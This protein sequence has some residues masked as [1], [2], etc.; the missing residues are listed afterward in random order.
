MV[1]ARKPSS[2]EVLSFARALLRA[3]REAECYAEEHC[4]VN[5]DPGTESCLVTSATFHSSTNASTP[6]LPSA[7]SQKQLQDLYDY[8]IRNSV[9]DLCS[10]LLAILPRG[11]TRNGRIEAALSPN[12]RHPI[13]FGST[14]LVAILDDISAAFRAQHDSLGRSNS[15]RVWVSDWK[16]DWRTQNLVW[17]V[18]KKLGFVQPP[19]GP[20]AASF[21]T[22]KEAAFACLFKSDY[23]PS[24]RRRCAFKETLQQCIPLPGKWDADLTWA[25]T[26]VFISF[27]FASL[28]H[29]WDVGRKA[30]TFWGTFLVSFTAISVTLLL[31]YASYRSRYSNKLLD[32]AARGTPYERAGGDGM[33]SVVTVRPS[34]NGEPTLTLSTPQTTTDITDESGFGRT[35]LTISSDVEGPDPEHEGGSVLRLYQASMFVERI[36]GSTFIDESWML[37]M[38]EPQLYDAILLVL[39]MAG[40]LGVSKS[41]TP[42]FSSV[43]ADCVLLTMATPVRFVLMQQS[44]KLPRFRFLAW[45]L[46]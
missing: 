27:P 35:S 14:D 34:R 31:L 38:T 9:D 8:C 46:Q 41:P 16:P 33:F 10:Y 45:S 1:R 42:V 4:G 29:S 32:K 7:K 36:Y 21:R 24:I 19:P 44:V 3:F 5:S 43:I 11:S 13:S 28:V 23:L 6:L 40:A 39:R 26:A 22:L 37:G 2:S 30:V 25:G 18:L 20:L 12:D 17:N 15:N